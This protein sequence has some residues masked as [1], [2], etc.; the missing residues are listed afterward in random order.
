MTVAANPIDGDI[1]FLT[2][3]PP[4]RCL[5]RKLSAGGLVPPHFQPR[6]QARTWH[7]QRTTNIH[8]VSCK[9]WLPRLSVERIS[10]IE[11]LQATTFVTF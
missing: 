7:R 5:T 3:E 2:L 10:T 8:G 11:T 1:S 9:E 4:L 6:C